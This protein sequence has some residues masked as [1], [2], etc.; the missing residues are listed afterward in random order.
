MQGRIFQHCYT[1]KKSVD[2]TVKYLASGCQ[3]T[4]RYSYVRLP[5]EHF[6]KSR[7]DGVMVTDSTRKYLCK[8]EGLYDQKQYMS[9]ATILCLIPENV[10][11][12]PMK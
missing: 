1:V 2:F 11:R 7:Y 6:Q 9:F 12:A 4:Y 10:L 5:V 8:V 3:F